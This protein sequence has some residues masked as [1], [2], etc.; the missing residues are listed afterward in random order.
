MFLLE[1][2]VSFP[3]KWS[4][5]FLKVCV[6]LGMSKLSL[7]YSYFTLGCLLTS[8]TES[9]GCKV[10]CSVTFR[11]VMLAGAESPEMFNCLLYVFILL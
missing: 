2:A 9:T 4:V 6:C 8:G 1:N 5:S 7:L 10:T 3:E 11:A